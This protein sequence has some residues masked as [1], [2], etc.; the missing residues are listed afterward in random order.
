MSSYSELIKNFERVRAYMRE[1]YVYGFKSR[2][3]YNKKARTHMMSGA[4]YRGIR[5]RG[6]EFI[7][8]ASTSQLLTSLLWRT[9]RLIFLNVQHR[10]ARMTILRMHQLSLLLLIIFSPS[11]SITPKPVPNFPPF[12]I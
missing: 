2:S 6:L 10:F 8:P 7:L 3:G 9:S 5:G 4:A 12:S 1:F 11:K